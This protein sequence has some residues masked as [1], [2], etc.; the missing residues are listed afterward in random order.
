MLDEKKFTEDILSRYANVMMEIYRRHEGI[1]AFLYRGVTTAYPITNIEFLCLQFRKTFELIVLSSLVANK[2]E[3]SKMRASFATDWHAENILKTI[4]KV[5]PNFYPVPTRQVV[6]NGQVIRTEDVKEGYLTKENL[7]TAFKDCCDLLHAEN[8]FA[9][10]KDK[11]S[12]TTKFDSW[13]RKTIMLLNHHQVQLTYTD[14]QIWCMINGG[15]EI[16]DNQR[17]HVS[18]FQRIS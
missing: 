18:L 9:E 5:N 10:T 8:P 16:P 14:Y 6:E 15:K 12:I 4:E 17:V 3:Y 1:K 13:L 11:L 7:I 2:E